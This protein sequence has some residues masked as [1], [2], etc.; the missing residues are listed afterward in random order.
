VNLYRARP[1]GL[2]QVVAEGQ[3]ALPALRHARSL[4]RLQDRRRVVVADGDG[5]NAGLVAI[6]P[7][8]ILDPGRVGQIERGG[9]ARSLR[10]AGIFEEIL[11][12]PALHAG[13]WP[14]RAHGVDVAFVVTVVLRVRVEQHANRAPL[15]GQIDLDA[16][17]VGTV[18]GDHNLAMKVDVLGGQLIEVLKPAVVGVDYLGGH[19]SRSRGAV[20]RHRDTRV[21]L[22]GVLVDVLA[23][24]SA[25]QQLAGRVVG[26]H[27]HG[28]GPIHQNAVGNNPGI[29]AG[30]A[31][32][33]R[34]IFGRLMIFGCRGQVWLGGQNLQVLSGKLRVGHG[35]KLLFDLGLRGKVRIAENGRRWSRCGRLALKQTGNR[36]EKEERGERLVQ[37]HERNQ[38]CRRIVEPA[39][40]VST[41]AGCGHPRKVLSILAVAAGAGLRATHPNLFYATGWVQ[42]EQ[43]FAAAGISL[44]HSAQVLVAGGATGAGPL[45]LAISVLSGST[46]KK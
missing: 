7:H 4:E 14:P 40:I 32:L 39:N 43:R 28:L 34:D 36:D 3:S 46:M 15:F 2:A 45:N 9:Y 11:N 42:W 35:Q 18:A 26:F 30:G 41:P 20:E 17:K 27:A 29:E 44:K 25:H 33:L 16:A 37:G 23:S 13:F 6:G 8:K 24:G 12:R 38:L 5:D 31:K 10:I 22:A 19:I 1:I 21:V